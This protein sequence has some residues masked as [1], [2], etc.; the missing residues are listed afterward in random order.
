MGSELGRGHSRGPKGEAADG[1]MGPAAVQLG[2]MQLLRPSICP[3]DL[4]P[5]LDVPGGGGVLPGVPPLRPGDPARLGFLPPRLALW[6]SHA[7]CRSSSSGL[8]RESE[9]APA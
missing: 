2:E 9:A 6:T 8:G 1:V 3:M 7:A 5:A 4:P